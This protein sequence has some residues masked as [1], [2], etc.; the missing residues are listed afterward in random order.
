[1]LILSILLV[2]LGL[3][4]VGGVVW[5]GFVITRAE[6]DSKNF[7]HHPISL[8]SHKLVIKKA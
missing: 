7:I 1:M 5:F 8:L 3:I 4:V 2:V 6:K